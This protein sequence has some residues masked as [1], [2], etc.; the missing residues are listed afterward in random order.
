MDSRIKKLAKTLVHHSIELKAG[1][2][3]YIDYKGSGADSFIQQLI[4]RL[5]DLI[6]SE[7]RQKSPSDLIHRGIGDIIFFTVHLQCG[8]A[9]ASGQNAAHQATE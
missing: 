1:E 8:D 3:V 6:L 9:A 7:Y 2:K 4:R 5:Q